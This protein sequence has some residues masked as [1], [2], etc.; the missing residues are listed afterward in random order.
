M[1]YIFDRKYSSKKLADLLKIVSANLRLA[2]HRT[3]ATPSFIADQ[4]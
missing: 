2:S 4:E 1:R 3:G